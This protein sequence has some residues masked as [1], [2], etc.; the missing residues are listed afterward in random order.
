[1]GLLMQTKRILLALTLG[2]LSLS[3]IWVGVNSEVFGQKIQGGKGTLFIGALPNRMLVID[4]STEKIID[5]ITLKTGAPRLVQ[6]SYN[7]KRL[8]FFF[9]V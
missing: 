5:E 7:R 1:M 2:V 3:A 9:T 6:S 8:Y 4:E